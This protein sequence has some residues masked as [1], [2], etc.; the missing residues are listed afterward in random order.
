LP[1]IAG[2]LACQANWS[3][4]R[5]VV[6]LNSAAFRWGALCASLKT[7]S[8]TER[9]DRLS[10]AGL[11]P[12][13]DP[14]SEGLLRRLL[15]LGMICALVVGVR[16]VPS[17]AGQS[18]APADHG[19]IPYRLTHQAADALEPLLAQLIAPYRD[20]C[21]MVVDARTNQILIQGPEHVQRIVH[22]FVDQAD[23][24]RSMRQS[25]QP[26]LRVYRIAA[27]DLAKAEFEVRAAYASDRQ[28]SVATDGASGQM[29]VL[30]PP[31]I[32]AELETRYE[33]ADSKSRP[34]QDDAIGSTAPGR[35][36]MQ[37]VPRHRHAVA[38]EVQL[39]QLLGDRL[40]HLADGAPRGPQYQWKL[41]RGVEARIVFD[42]T[43]G[44]IRI[45]APP[46]VGA[47]I[48]RLIGILDGPAAPTGRAVRIVPLQHAELSKVL[49]AARSAGAA[50]H[51][52]SERPKLPVGGTPNQ[53]RA[54]APSPGTGSHSAPLYRSAVPLIGSLFQTED[55]VVRTAGFEAAE[56]FVA[57]PADGG[58][59]EPTGED[60]VQQ[61]LRALG[62]DLDIET[63]PDLDVIILR[64][65][66][67]DVDELIRII[68]EI[69]RI[70]AENEP[71]IE[72]VALQHVKDEAVD[73]LVD[74]IRQDL[75]ARRQGQVSITPLVKPNGLLLIGWGDAFR[76]AKELIQKLD[77]PVDPD[78]QLQVFRL[79]NTPAASARATVQEFFAAR[80]GLGARVTVTADVRSNSLFVQASPRDLQEVELL[81]NRLDTPGS[82]AVNEVRVFTLKNSLATDLARILEAAIQPTGTPRAGPA[83][84]KSSSLELMSIGAEGARVIKSGVLSDVSVT[85]DPQKNT[86]IVTAPAESMELL[87]A[88]IE[89][90][91]ASPPAVAQIKVFRIF[92]GEAN[93]LVQ[94]LRSLLPEKTGGG[95]GP[96]LPGA[97]GETSFVP[98]RLSVDERTNSIIATGSAGDLNIIQAL[99]IRL[100]E[101][102][103]RSRQNSVY[104]LKNAPA[105]D[106][107]N[108][109]NDLLRS[110]RQ[111]E[112]A[113]PGA[114]SP[115][116][117]IEREVV[118]VPEVVSNSLI[119]SATPRFYDEVLKLVEELDAQPPQVIIQVVIAQV[120]LN[121]T[122]EFG[123]ELGLQDSLLF[124]RSLLGDLLT[125]INTVQQSTDQGIITDTTEIIRSAELSPGFIFNNHTLGNSGSDRALARSNKVG[126]QGLSSFSL[127]RVNSELGFGGLV[128]SASSESVS[129]LVRLLQESRRLEILSR[130]QVTTLDNQPAYIQVGQRVPRIVGTQL[131][132][133]GQINTVEL[134]NV[135]LILG[136][137]PRIS[138]SG[139]VVMEIDAE[140][141]EVG[142]EAEGIPISVTD[143]GE[144]IR[145]PRIDTATAQ[146]T[147][148][149]ASGETIVLGG[150]ITRR[151]ETIHRNVPY[152]KDI[153]LLGHLFRYD[154]MSS[155]RFELLIIMTPHVIR[156]PDDA[157]RIR[158]IEE[159]RMSWTAGDVQE[160]HG[161][162]GTCGNDACPYCQSNTQVI[163]PDLNPRGILDESISPPIEELPPLEG[164]PTD[165][166]ATD[167]PSA[168]SLEPEPIE[169]LSYE[170]AVSLGGPDEKTSASRLL[171]WPRL[172]KTAPPPQR[173]PKHPAQE[174][175]KDSSAATAGA[176]RPARLPTMGD[177][178]PLSLEPWPIE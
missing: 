53:G 54:A 41:D 142:P 96:Q 163:Y 153:P 85:P 128:L 31:A 154:L 104:R 39:K 138:P 2:I 127:G 5:N 126:G 17:A 86:L 34:E 51:A 60:A 164:P 95:A 109:I 168:D 29:F 1:Q 73:R 92:N 113:P 99:L 171:R 81:I 148:S 84:Q 133:F 112:Q 67:Q 50:E 141:S 117:Q 11:W 169:P 56:D 36:E 64:G 177:D 170:Q 33:A 38:L 40:V 120:V 110:Q 48:E 143:T 136:V 146:T 151:K 145:S 118:V 62:G 89:R 14:H 23:R 102:E 132:N 80:T 7:L 150:L 8:S 108:A 10:P 162:G 103:I 55:G 13:F 57:D 19:F 114:I 18:T 58:T 173:P 25:A 83:G 21:E 158:H 91:D 174:A 47:Q 52:A 3:W 159:C 93:S 135:G 165:P 43:H 59:E 69:E 152:L 63:L 107:A 77:Q 94:M 42:R 82:E 68:E 122:D 156:T 111:I 79:R 30:A 176:H 137:T 71:L 167:G 161:A 166:P 149:A 134:E 75:F 100:D 76:A 70:S 178:E 98:L 27:G 28:V 9:M 101:R 78:T 144:V 24:P 125:T 65:S 116:Q 175:A 147:V 106:V 157:Q 6:P 123:V 90:L 4:N 140:R 32:H 87:A 105:L 12:R 131:T 97:E 37:V 61:R 22:Q 155:R 44:L 124:D 16:E 172:R 160:L 26:V 139:L 72:V 66:N 74:E 130:P 46:K 88:L 121:D 119:I 49:E 15:A 115:F 129:V 20:Q 35:V 45:D